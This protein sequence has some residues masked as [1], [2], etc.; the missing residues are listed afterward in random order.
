MSVR[1]RDA[2]RF[3]VPVTHHGEGPFWDTRTLRLLCMDVLVGDVVSIEQSGT[4]TRHHLPARV[5]TVIR[6]RASGGFVLSTERG[7]MFADEDLSGFICMPDVLHDP[8]IRTNDGGCDP[9]GGFVMGT[10]A[11]QETPGAGAVYR[12]A[13]NGEVTVLLRN[14][15]ISNGVQ[16]SVDGAFVYYIDSPTRRIDVFDFDR[17]FGGWS[18]RRPHVTL[19]GWGV[20]DGMA[21][22]EDGGLWVA[23]WGA[24]TVHHYDIHGRL[25]EMV[26]VP[27]VSQVSSCTFGGAQLDLLFISTSRKGLSEESEANAGAIY[28]IQTEVRGVVPFEFSG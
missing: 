12:L 19:D 23:I 13:P 25:V 8:A 17:S 10:M 1:V 4:W 22:D 18:N 20:P 7:F 14:V 6:R 16:W 9:L 3:T 11:Y 28:C 27:G 26:N 2:D 24:G 15:S 5:A 21:I